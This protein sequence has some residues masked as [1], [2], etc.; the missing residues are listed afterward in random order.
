MMGWALATGMDVGGW[1]L[2]RGMDVS[3]GNG[4]LVNVERVLVRWSLGYH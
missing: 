3:D 4:Q 1:P 2:E